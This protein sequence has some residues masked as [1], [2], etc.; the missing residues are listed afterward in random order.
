[1]SSKPEG[2][3]AAV[4]AMAFPWRAQ[5]GPLNREV[6]PPEILRALK[7]NKIPLLSLREEGL[8]RAPSFADSAEFVRAREEARRSLAHF[9]EEHRLVG[10]ILRAE[11][12]PYLFLKSAGPFPYE[13]D[14]FDLLVH[15]GLRSRLE[16]LL[17]PLGYVPQRQYRE[18]WKYLFKR[19]ESG[20][21]RNI[22][23]F[24][25]EVS[26]GVECF[27]DISEF[28][29]RS[30]VS[31]DDASIRVPAA[32]D[33]FLTTMAHGIYENDQFKLG[34]LLKVHHVIHRAQGDLDWDYMAEVTAKR[35]WR[36]GFAFI[37]ELLYRMEN[38]F[39]GES[40]VPRQVLLSRG[41]SNRF[42]RKARE[43]YATGEFPAPV[44][45]CFS[46]WLFLRKI[47]SNPRNSG[48]DSLRGLAGFLRDN[49]E[50]LLRISNQRGRLIA[51]SGVDG[52]G[53]STV[54]DQVAYVLDALELKHRRV[55]VRAGNSVLM[56]AFNRLGRWLLKGLI[57]RITSRDHSTAEKTPARH[58][59]LRITNPLASRL[60]FNLTLGELVLQLLF[61][62]KIPLAF[63]RVVVC[64]RYLADSIV[65]LMVRCNMTG[66]GDSIPRSVY[67][68]MFPKPDL[69]LHLRVSPEASLA[70]KREEFNREQ[71]AARCELYSRVSQFWKMREIDTER[72][73]DIVFDDVTRL[74][75]HTLYTE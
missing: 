50:A 66:P 53:K 57:G 27:L 2:I 26:W 11:S 47:F 74:L 4:L 46:K 67:Y 35:G 32:E 58:A 21:L 43:L 7:R 64:D 3:T 56:Q 25:E 34:D 72:D 65:D 48:L 8:R 20:R 37:L 73:L 54:L 70:R 55:W 15:K 18:D 36:D 6:E 9:S 59:E 42:R 19:F 5:P 44:G 41:F 33:C 13:S 49:T 38:G 61:R 62:V 40:V 45:L 68:K 23:H 60:W 12:I 14:N 63:G 51:V 17:S 52:S 75:A 1:M 16:N 28:W 10:E 39:W 24:H 22:L 69:S 30:L 31:P 71:L 29:R